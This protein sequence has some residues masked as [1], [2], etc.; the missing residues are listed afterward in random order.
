MGRHEGAYFRALGSENS[1]FWAAGGDCG[2]AGTVFIGGGTPT[3]VNPGHIAGLLAQIP[4]GAG[5]EV[6]IESNPGTLDADKLRVYAGAGVNRLSIGCQ[7][8]HDS[9]L[10]MLGRIHTY[11]DFLKSVRA[12]KNTGFTNINA[13]LLFGLP[14][15]VFSEWERTLETVVALGVSHLSCYSLSL[16]EGTPLYKAV[17]DGALPNPDEELDRR[18]YGFAAAYLRTAGLYQYEISNFAKPGCECRHNLTYWDGSRYIGLGAGAHSYDGR[19]RFSNTPSINGYIGR[20][21]GAS[22]SAVAE[23]V[24]INADEKE[25]EYLILRL[26]LTRGFSEA[27]F[28][29]EFGYRFID[30]YKSAADKLSEEG[31]IDTHTEIGRVRLTP[32]GMDLANRVF[33]EFV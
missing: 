22:K 19:K 11:D 6:T 27:E 15:Q 7:S 9:H 13:D 33:V 31:L 26:R 25:K 3:S 23:C 32:L 2:H 12:A 20:M 21:E 24:E 28:Y 16:E 8:T 29:R 14:G 5:C 17:R 18:M 1:A 10:K 4:R 30:K